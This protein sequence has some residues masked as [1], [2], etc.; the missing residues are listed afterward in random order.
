[1]YIHVHVDVHVHVVMRDE[2]RKEE[3][4]KQG[5]TN[6]KAKQYSTP[7]AVTLHVTH[8]TGL[9]CCPVIWLACCHCCHGELVWKVQVQ[10]MYMYIV[11]LYA[12][13]FI[14]LIPWPSV[15]GEDSLSRMGLRSQEYCLP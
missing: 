15:K 6:N 5:Q 11:Y 1:M 3:G 10:Y 8:S 14:D 13:V 9:R 2:R 12:D 4:S 7:K